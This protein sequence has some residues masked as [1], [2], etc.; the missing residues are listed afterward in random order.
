MTVVRSQ[1]AHAQFAK[2]FQLHALVYVRTVCMYV[3]MYVQYVHHDNNVRM[4]V[5]IVIYCNVCVCMHYVMQQ[6]LI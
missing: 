4:Y 2:P 3:C 1:Q 6:V 5:G